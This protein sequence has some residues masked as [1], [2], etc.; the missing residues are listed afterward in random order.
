MKI[1]LGQIMV[2]K[3]ITI[4]QASLLTGVPRSTISDILNGRTM[5]R[6]DTMEQLA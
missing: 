2:K 3:N 4:R 1:L 5:P 6:L